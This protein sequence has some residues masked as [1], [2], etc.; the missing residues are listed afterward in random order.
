M[1][2]VQ[3]E[4]ETR[5]AFDCTSALSPIAGRELVLDQPVGGGGVGHPQQ[6]LGQHHERQP[7]PGGQRIGVQEILDA[8]EPAGMG[9]DALD[10]ARGARIDARLGRSRARD[11]GQQPRRDRL[12]GRRI[13]CG[14]SAA[15]VLIRVLDVGVS[16]RLRSSASLDCGQ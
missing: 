11:R 6:R 14:K 12:V 1:P 2:S 5:S 4:A 13:G 7:L 3:A 9:A 8:A 16:L 15:A 10:Q